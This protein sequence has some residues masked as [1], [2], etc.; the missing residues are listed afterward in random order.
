MLKI[1]GSISDV[2]E[3]QDGLVTE[4]QAIAAGATPAALKELTE[5][6][7]IEP[8]LPGVVRLRGGARPPFPR[9]YAYWLLLAPDQPAWSRPLPA[10]GVVSHSAAVRVY[11]VGNLPG[12]AAEFTVPEQGTTTVPDGVLVH[13]A[14]LQTDEYRVV[15]GVP[16]TAPGRTLADLVSEGSTDL[17]E[18]GRIATNFLG[19]GLT[20][21]AELEKAL[22]R[23]A[24]VP[25]GPGAGAGLLAILLANVDGAESTVVPEETK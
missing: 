17:E 20:T 18:L 25:G 3:G 9:L 6:R 10:A 16:V 7:V 11:G 5:S 15:G 8:V 21:R 4:D 13:H 2:A 22:E 14:E 23:Q 1:V 19:K 12:P 24:G